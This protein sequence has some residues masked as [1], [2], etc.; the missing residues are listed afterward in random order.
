[1]DD[2]CCELVNPAGPVHCHD[3]VTEVAVVAERFKVESLQTGPLEVITGVTGVE[4]TT[5]VIVPG[6]ETHEAMVTV[7]E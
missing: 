3:I 6:N 1:M 7:T 5:T 2:D 4:S